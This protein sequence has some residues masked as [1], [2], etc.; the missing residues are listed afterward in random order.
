MKSFMYFSR[1]TDRCIAGRMLD[2]VFGGSSGGS[3]KN[4]GMD[5][6][7]LD[8]IADDTPDDTLTIPDDTRT[9][10]DRCSRRQFCFR[11]GIG[12]GRSNIPMTHTA[13]VCRKAPETMALARPLT[14][15]TAQVWAARECTV[16]K[17]L[18]PEIM[19][20]TRPVPGTR[21]QVILA[22]DTTAQALPAPEVMT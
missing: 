10:A 19:L 1:R 13:A 18:A 4:G 8:D 14:G 7:G 16:Q 3:D 20:M 22:Q 11:I 2:T 6:I 5:M 9:T 17:W 21:V 15:T 12:G